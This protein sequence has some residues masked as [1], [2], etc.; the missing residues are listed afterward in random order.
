MESGIRVFLIQKESVVFAVED[1]EHP[2]IL[3]ERGPVHKTLRLLVGLVGDLDPNLY[4]FATGG[5]DG[6]GA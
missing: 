5:I 3:P 1:K 4:F 6:Y 2:P